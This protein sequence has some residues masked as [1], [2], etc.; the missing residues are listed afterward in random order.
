MHIFFIFKL[1]CLT[2][3]RTADKKTD[4]WAIHFT[5]IPTENGITII[6][7]LCGVLFNSEL[8]SVN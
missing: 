4:N 1:F 6:T 7:L 3:H 5:C 2:F 8:Y